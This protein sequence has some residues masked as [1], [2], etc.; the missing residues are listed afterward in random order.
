MDLFRVY[1]IVFLADIT[2]GIVIPTFP[3]YAESIGASVFLLS[4]VVTG[5]GIARILSQVYLGA[6]AD[7]KGRKIVQIIGLLLFTSFPILTIAIHTPALLTIPLMMQGAGTI[8]FIMAASQVGDLVNKNEINKKMGMLIFIQGIGFSIGPFIGGF[9]IE[10]FGFRSAY[11][12]SSSFSLL[13][14]LIAFG[15]KEKSPQ[16]NSASDDR[17]FIIKT[18]EILKKESILY[19]GLLTILMLLGFRSFIT[20][21]PLRG[22]EL[23]MNAA[24]IG[25]IVGVRTISST[26][27]RLPAGYLAESFGRRP[28][29]IIALILSSLGLAIFATFSN[30]W[31]ILLAASLEG[32]GFGIFLTVSRAF[33]VDSTDKS[34]RSTSLS[35]TSSLGFLGQTI[36]ILLLGSIS[37]F[38]G[39]V[40]VFAIGS[41]FILSLGLLLHVKF[42]S[43]SS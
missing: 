34:N 29:F 33:V 5:M 36:M 16:G 20:F 23:G 22:F 4:I 37:D 40:L 41:V 7:V 24:L 43:V 10:E 12:L 19:V 32:A 9:V 11:Y 30:L 35:I 38:V 21:F 31:M 39:L 42:R 15:L 6:L 28:L 13:A 8:V 18:K 3:L 26:I 1:A 25:S 17:S 14:I 27:F 2:V